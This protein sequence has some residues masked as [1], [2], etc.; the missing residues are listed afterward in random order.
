MHKTRW[1]WVCLGVGLAV[2]IGAVLKQVQPYRTQVQSAQM[3]SELQQTAPL[4]VQS[5]GEINGGHLEKLE[6]GIS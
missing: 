1:A 2:I 6:P 4:L 5:M 3:P